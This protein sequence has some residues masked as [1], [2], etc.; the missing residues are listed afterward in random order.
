[1]SKFWSPLTASLVPYVPGEQ[2]KDKTYIKLNTN[3]NP[4]PPSPKVIDAI[5]AAANA[6]L[7]L[8]PD[9]TCEGL[10]QAAAAYYGLP[11][12]QVFAGNG[13]DEIL[14]FAFAAFFDPAKKLLF[15]DITYSFYKVY[16]KL[17]GLQTELIPLDEQFNVQVDRF[18]SD[19]GGVIIPNP[20]APTAQLLPLDEIRALLENNPNQA[21]VIDEAYIDF[22]G[23][24]AVQ[25]ISEYPNLLVVQT[26]SKSRSLA[27]LR[28]GFAFGS[29]ELI[30]GLNRIKNSFNSY[31]L[32][33]LALAG[34]VA[35]FEDEAYFRETTAKVIATRERVTEQ[36]ISLGF[37]ATE[38][39]ANFVFISHP[40]IAAKGI[41]QQ[42]RDRGVLVRYFDQPRINEYLRVSIGTDEEMDALI[43]A[44]REIAGS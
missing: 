38:S 14:A 16:A 31:T 18:H 32:D 19:N 9:P 35:S 21:V 1:M 30:E 43:A 6:D 29:E 17:Y 37:K 12:Q 44:L 2:P 41:F 26:L 39:K 36:V 33:R 15:P 7:R 23:E 4:Y 20:N 5:K 3:E 13:S 11:A 10:I 24:S 27:G 34:A 40:S 25:L 28:V 8:Y 22:G 42:L